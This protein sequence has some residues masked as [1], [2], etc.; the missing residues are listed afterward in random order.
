MIRIPVDP[1][2]RDPL[3]ALKILIGIAGLILLG[4]YCSIHPDRV[5]KVVL[6]RIFSPLISAWISN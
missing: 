1:E 6:K 3:S 5:W 2:R 4:V